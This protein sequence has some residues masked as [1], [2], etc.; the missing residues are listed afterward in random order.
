MRWIIAGL[1]VAAGVAA[2]WEHFEMTR[3]LDS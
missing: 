1:M 2:A 3:S